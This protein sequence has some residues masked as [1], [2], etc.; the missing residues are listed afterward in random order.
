M[1][2]AIN[3]YYQKAVYSVNA[4]SMTTVTLPT[5]ANYFHLVNM[6][7][8]TMYF[9][10]TRIPSADS[11][12]MKIPAGS[13][14]MHVEPYGKT[15][16][17]IYNDG[18]Q[19]GD[20]VLLNFSADFDPLVLA[21]AGFESGGSG[22][23]SVSGGGSSFDGVIKGFDTALPSGNNTLGNVI[24]VENNQLTQ[25]INALKGATPAGTNKI[26]SVDIANST[27]LAGILS[28]LTAPE[29][30]LFNSGNSSATGVTVSATSGRK[31]TCITFLSNDGE[32]DLSVTV[33][34]ATFTLKSGEVLDNF[35]VYV[36]SIKILGNS[37]PYR[38]AY[39]EKEGV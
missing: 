23:G 7:T 35:K 11:F 15:Q 10:A 14:R 29:H 33:G 28:A 17:H 31:I 9:S 38:L 4:K 2:K 39:N 25:I 18:S 26:G 12:D 32:A 24:L 1:N 5:S 34:D 20:F 16:V 6:G 19:K 8:G 21:M 36:D 13:A 3:S 37:V 30:G 27:Q 22:G